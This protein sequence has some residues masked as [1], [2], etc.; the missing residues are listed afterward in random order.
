VRVKREEC[1]S[2]FACARACS[3]SA[4]R[5]GGVWR[6]AEDIAEIARRDQ[7]FYKESDGGVT[8]SGGEPL[9]QAAFV[10]RLMSL[11]KSIPVHTALETSGMGDE[12]ALIR[13]ANLTDLLYFDVKILDDET[14][15]HYTG[16]S[17]API[18]SN[19]R[20]LAARDNLRRRVCVRT[21]CIPGVNDSPEQ[22]RSIAALARSLGIGM[23][24]ALRYN[25]AADA[26]Y[27]WLDQP[28]PLGNVR[29]RDAAYYRGLS[30]IVKSEG[31]AGAA[32]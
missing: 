31:L 25:A 21:P 27:E 1:A 8:V 5:V 32:G 15:K 9:A 24:E 22:I 14:H 18:L 16:V 2:C 20:A 13:I 6:E 10:E 11:L 7:D 29:E 3:T 19:L 12:A 26:K 4:L 23:M 30:D 28:Y 17:N